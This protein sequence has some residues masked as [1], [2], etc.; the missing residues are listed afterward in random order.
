MVLTWLQFCFG[1]KP[2]LSEDDLDDA[3][4]GDKTDTNK[5]RYDERSDRI[6]LGGDE[7]DSDVEDSSSAKGKGKG[8]GQPAER[9]RYPNG[10]YNR[11]YVPRGSRERSP[12]GSSGSRV[13]GR[14]VDRSARYSSYYGNYESYGPGHYGTA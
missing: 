2:P 13:G 10:K 4:W 11:P 9:E 7:G 14:E 6:K 8:K 3:D 5:V 1:K 12:S